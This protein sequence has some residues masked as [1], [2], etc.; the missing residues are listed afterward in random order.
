M[1]MTMH[2][3]TAGSGYQYLMRSTASG[4]CDRPAA[5]DLTTY[6]AASGNPPG[7]WYG[8][9]LVG[10]ASGGPGDGA[11]VTEEEM[12]NLYGEG[13]DPRTGASLGRPYPRHTP[14][15]ERIAKQ[16]A[17]LP[18]DLA[19]E[20]RDAAVAAITRVELAK[21]T[22]TAVAGFDLTFTATKSVSTLWALADDGTRA[23]LLAAHRAAVGQALAFLEDT[24]AFTRTGTAGCRQH[25]VSGLIAA[26]FDHWDSRAGDPNLHTHLVVANKVQGPGGAW[27][28]VDSRALHHAVVMVSEMYDDLLAD[29]VARR[30]PVAFGWRHRGPR[31]SPAFELDGVD[32]ALMTEFSSRATQIDEAMTGVLAEFY[33]T[34]GRGPNRIEI[35]RL[36]QQVTRSVRPKKHVTP[37]ADLMTMWRARASE[38]TG[39]TPAELTAAVLRASQAAPLACDRIP[40]PVI[41]RLAEHTLEQVMTRRSTWTRWNVMAEAARATRAIRMTGPTD[42]GALLERVTNA[43]LRS[44]TSLQAPDPFA[45]PTR[46]T[47]PD[48]TSQ[49]TRVDEGRYTHHQVLDAEARL[50]HAAICDADAPTTAAWLAKAVTS[51]PI[52]STDGRTVTLA[53]DQA[54]AVEHIAGSTRLLNVLVGPAGT[55]KTTTLAALKAAWEQGHGRG[56]VVGLAPSATAAAELGHALGIACENT[57]KWL[58]ES[59]GPGAQ[60][61]TEL[62]ARLHTERADATGFDQRTRLRTIDTAITTLTALGDRFR[63]RPGQLLIVDEASLAGTFALDALTAEA[64]DVGAKV[65]L[66]GDH[67]Q[68]SAVDAGGAFHLLAE[69]GRPATLTSLWRFTH[70][71][72]AAATLRLRTGDIHVIDDYADHD[73]ISAGPAEAMCE[74]AYTAWQTDTERGVSAILIASDSRTVDILNTRAHSDRVTDGLVTPTGVTTSTGTEIGVGDHV[75]TRANDRRLRTPGGHVRNGDLWQVTA[76]ASDGALT[77]V[78]L[79]RRDRTASARADEVVIPAVYAGQHV[80][81][82]YATTTHRAQGIT[83]DRAHVLAGPGMVRE[84]LYVAMTR[85]RHDNHVYLALDTIEAACDYPPEHQI[86]QGG[87]DALEAILTTPGAELSATETIAASQDEVASP[88]RLLRIRHTLLADAAAE[89]WGA[90]FPTVGLTADQCD[91]ITTSPARGPL[92]TALERGRALG[93]P[94]HEVL[95][96]LIAARPLDGT[97]PAAETASVLHHRV[98]EWLRAHIEDPAEVPTVDDASDAPPETVAVLDQIDGLIAARAPALSGFELSVASHGDPEA[99]VDEVP[100]RTPFAPMPSPETQR[101]MDQ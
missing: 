56:S 93:H 9:G 31:R 22:S 62:L 58:Y 69:R 24:A 19:D 82:G 38:R 53:Q 42:R 95:A 65:L 71:W 50:L 43:A 21:R 13:K 8:R 55:G 64:S 74:D 85:G 2:R 70:P 6:Y 72:E 89:R 98:H 88:R 77:V 44:C 63:L 48:G 80:E 90:A 57:A 68:L 41:D 15:A 45:V 94:M 78:P 39:K 86:S 59:T 49:F 92:L 51:R 87:R 1:V 83:V 99:A 47:R 91:Q 101:S 5:S 54:T 66:V 37:L 46:Y 28:S 7:R 14:A 52:H 73:R 11:H 84:N 12:A 34:H 61:R 67:K 60:R 75:I 10:L 25:K 96:G 81:L 26:G 33:A 97:H 79:S 20:A 40:G 76:V 23:A 36:R 32:D 29:E 17:A 18:A 3:L 100:S 27:L 35:V 30:L 4:D 16:V